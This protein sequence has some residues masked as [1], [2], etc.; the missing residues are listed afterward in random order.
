MATSKKICIA[1]T[2]LK[3]IKRYMDAEALLSQVASEPRSCRS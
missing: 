3:K 1:T 2:G